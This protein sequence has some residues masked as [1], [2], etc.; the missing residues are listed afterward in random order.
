MLREG[1]DVP[2]VSVICLL[3]GFGSPLFAHQVLG[4]GLRLIRRNG[5]G[6]D[7]SI[8]ELT[9]IDHPCLQ[10]DDLW[11]EIDA[12]VRAGEEITRERELPRDGT[13]RTNDDGQE[14]LPEQVV[15]RQDLYNLLFPVPSPKTVD[16]ITTERAMELLEQ[17]L[18]V[19]QKYR[20]EETVIVSVEITEVEKLRP[21]RHVEMAEKPLKVTA[22]P[23]D[24]NYGEFALAHFKR[25]IEAWAS[26][27]CDR[28]QPLVTHEALVYRGILQAFESHV[29]LGQSI[30]EV[31]AVKLF[32]AYHM[33][34]QLREA[35]TY[36]MNHHIYAEEVL[37][38]E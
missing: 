13:G 34:P 12:L 31:P 10:L 25:Q 11:A 1:W 22:L 16:G 24:S 15:V 30:I 14:M 19:L 2:E 3:R 27:Y 26:D 21:K 5:L 7:R 35:V 6:T 33:V 37:H 28:Y 4:R 9:V 18:T 38:N 23:T 17:S 32:A 29:F 36:D 8:Q 20:P